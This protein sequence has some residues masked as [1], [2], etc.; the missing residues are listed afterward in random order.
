[1]LFIRF[2][3]KSNQDIPCSFPESK[4]KIIKF[5]PSFLPKELWKSF[6]AFNKDNL[7]YIGKGSRHG[8]FVSEEILPEDR[9]QV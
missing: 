5:H 9:L 2:N 8:S 6:I 1:M 4:F 7:D 3:E